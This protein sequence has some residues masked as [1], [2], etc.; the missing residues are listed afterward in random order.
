MA[1]SRIAGILFTATLIAF[2]DQ[3]AARTEERLGEVGAVR[4]HAIVV[5]S[6][7]EATGFWRAIGWQQQGDRLRFV[8][9]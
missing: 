7:A 6:D 2:I 4:L 5:E 8:K 1:R 9:G 3:A